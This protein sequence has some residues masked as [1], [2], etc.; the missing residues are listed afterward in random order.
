M[1]PCPVNSFGGKMGSSFRKG[2]GQFS[3]RTVATQ[4]AKQVGVRIR[5]LRQRSGWTQVELAQRLGVDEVTVRRWELGHYLPATENLDKLV[6]L[7]G[8]SSEELLSGLG[9]MGEA[10]EDVSDPDLRLFFRGSGTS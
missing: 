7:F 3:A 10:R 2:G 5:S 8:M 6:E 9:E 1:V 4:M